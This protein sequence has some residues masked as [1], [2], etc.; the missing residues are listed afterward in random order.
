MRTTEPRLGVVYEHPEWFA[1]LFAELDH[2]GIPYDRVDVSAHRVRPGRRPRP[3]A[4]VLNRMSPS[5]YLRGHAAAIVH[6]REYLRYLAAS[7]ADVI[8][9]ADAFAL[10]TSK[11]AQLLLLRRLA[12]PAPRTRVINDVRLA[13]DAAEG[14]RFPVAVKPNIGGSGAGIQRYDTPE[15]LRRAVD[16]GVLDLGIDRTA[17][18]QEFLP[19]RGGHIVRVEVLGGRFLYAIKVYPNPTVRPVRRHLSARRGGLGRHGVGGGPVPGRPPEGRAARRRLH[20]ARAGD[21]GSVAIARTA[22]LDIAGVEYLVNDRDGEI[23][24]YDINALSNFVA[25]AQA[26]V[27]FNPYASL[28]DYVA[29]RG[30][31]RVPVPAGA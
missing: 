8:N 25:N 23:Y 22:G 2:R 11:V 17:L 24:Y 19:A 10:E 20:A 29:L 28:V 14:F 5:A 9:G 16:D 1:P 31:F 12:L 30:R 3:G 4:L 18:V 13:A 27:G 26:V 21:R 15:A 7:G 6:A